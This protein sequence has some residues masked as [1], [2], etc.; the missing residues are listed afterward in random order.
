MFAEGTVI[1][2]W[3]EIELSASV[4]RIGSE[5]KW[6]IPVDLLLKKPFHIGDV[7]PYVAIGPTI[8]FVR[9]EENIVGVGAAAVVGVYVWLSDSWGIDIELDYALV[10]EDGAQHE[11]TFAAGP[12]LRF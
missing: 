5:D 9:G 7:T 11:L 10:D 2:G 4:V 8:A 12:T 1:E 3:L 6:V